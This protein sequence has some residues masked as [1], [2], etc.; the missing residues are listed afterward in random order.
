MT[1]T[2]TLAYLI[3]KYMLWWCWHRPPRIHTLSLD[4]ILCLWTTIYHW[5]PQLKSWPA[6]PNLLHLQSHLLMTHLTSSLF[7]FSIS[8]LQEFI[9]TSS[10]HFL[11]SR[12]LLI[13]FTLSFRH[14]LVFLDNNSPQLWGWP[15]LSDLLCLQLMASHIILVKIDLPGIHWPYPAAVYFLPDVPS[16][17][18]PASCHLP[19]SILPLHASLGDLV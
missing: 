2:V 12:R 19:G 18:S 11:L 3:T 6:L 10:G 9:G 8:T 14:H 16:L 7:V 1:F 17:P 5:S 4:I 13:L 15:T